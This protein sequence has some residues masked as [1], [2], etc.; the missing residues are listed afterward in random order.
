M[1]FFAAIVP[2]VAL[3]LHA[4]SP[5]PAQTAPA[6]T[7]PRPAPQAAPAAPAPPTAPVPRSLGKFGAFQAFEFADPA[8]KVCY[9]TAAPAKSESKPEGA[10]RGEIRLT[11]SHRTAQKT[12]DEVTFQAGYPPA[13]DKRVV[14]TVDQAK[15][16]EFPRGAPASPETR[17][18]RD[19]DIDKALVA[20]LRAGKEMTVAAT[21]ARG[22]RTND[23]FPLA[24]FGRALD[25]INR[26]CNVT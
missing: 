18:T 13:A 25:A 14:A 12:R 4:A 26:A 16:F 9:L 7:A 17:W 24:G 1:R 3:A 22:T 10:R 8:G 19:A 23:V 20:A 2:V 21:S 11:V 15:F 5:A 6:Q